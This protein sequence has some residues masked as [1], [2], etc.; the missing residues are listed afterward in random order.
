M[1]RTLYNGFGPFSHRTNKPF[2]TVV[3]PDLQCSAVH[4]SL[5]WGFRVTLSGLSWKTVSYCHLSVEW[6]LFPLP[7]PCTLRYATLHP[8]LRILGGTPVNWS[9]RPRKGQFVPW[10]LV[11]SSPLGAAVVP[12]DLPWSPGTLRPARLPGLA[13]I[14]QMGSRIF[15]TNKKNSW[16]ALL[17]LKRSQNF[18][19]INI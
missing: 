16:G 3:C 4:Y 15:Q 5:I 14:L 9:T 19:N 6:V 12:W 18:R 17:N 7:E 11:S 10:F 8:A 1:A 2:E 13:A